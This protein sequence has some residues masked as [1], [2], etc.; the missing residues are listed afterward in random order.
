MVNRTKQTTKDKSGLKGGPNTLNQAKLDF[1]QK[2]QVLPEQGQRQLIQT[3]K[4]TPKR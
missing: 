2:V 4:L 3:P 1:T